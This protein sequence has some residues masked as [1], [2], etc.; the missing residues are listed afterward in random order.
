MNRIQRRTRNDA[1]ADRHDATTQWDAATERDDG[2][3]FGWWHDAADDRFQRADGVY[4]SA[5]KSLRAGI[6]IVGSKHERWEGE[7]GPW[8]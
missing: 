2:D 6:P 5:T 1:T 3:E 7:M 8:R 4:G